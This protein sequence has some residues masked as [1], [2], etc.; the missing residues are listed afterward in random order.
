MALYGLYA[1]PRQGQPNAIAVSIKES[2]MWEPGVRGQM[3]SMQSLANA[4]PMH[5]K[6]I[7][8]G[9]LYGSRVSGGNNVQYYM[10]PKMF[11]L[12]MGTPYITVLLHYKSSIG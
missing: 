3:A 9:A 11:G 4:N 2:Y 12:S 1:E 8:I 7:Y 5:P 6:S 10:G